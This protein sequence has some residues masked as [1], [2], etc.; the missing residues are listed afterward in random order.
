MLTLVA[1]AQRSGKTLYVVRRVI[2]D[3]DAKRPAAPIWSNID[4]DHPAATRLPWADLL[5]P[6]LPAGYVIWDEAARAWDSRKSMSATISMLAG[7]TEEG[8]SLRDVYM[9]AQDF[10]MVDSRIRRMTSTAVKITGR[11]FTK[12]FH[13]PVTDELVKRRHPRWLKIQKGS[14]LFADKGAGAKNINVKSSIYLPWF[15]FAPFTGRYDTAEKVAVADHLAAGKD[16]Y[17]DQRTDLAHDLTRRI[18]AQRPRGNPRH[19]R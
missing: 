19:A 11:F 16:F 10:G 6:E 2:K 8:K 15:L 3:H 9:T 4:V 13:D 18:D 12:D 1:G 14:W 7:I 5:D 17:R